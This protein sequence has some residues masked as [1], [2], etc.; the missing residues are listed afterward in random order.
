MTID[1]SRKA[2]DSKQKRMRLLGV[3]VGRAVQKSPDMQD[4]QSSLYLGPASPALPPRL[5][6][7]R[8]PRT[9]DH[10]QSA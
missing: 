7:A 10:S 1:S 2:R 5:S 4:G 9:A 3:V 6:S 8:A